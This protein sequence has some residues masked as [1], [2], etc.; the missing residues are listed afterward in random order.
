MS[1]QGSGR[2]RSELARRIHEGPDFE[3][4]GLT[5]SAKIGRISLLPPI[6]PALNDSSALREQWC[7]LRCSTWRDRNRSKAVDDKADEIRVERALAQAT[8]VR[9]FAEVLHEAKSYEKARCA[10]AR[11]EATPFGLDT[12]FV[13]TKIEGVSPDRMYETL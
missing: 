4:A 13:V 7:R 3:L 2:P 9:G 1:V 10:V 11:I 12:C 5:Y 8:C 6:R